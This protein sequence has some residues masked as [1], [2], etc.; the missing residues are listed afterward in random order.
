MPILSVPIYYS[1]CNYSPQTPVVADAHHLVLVSLFID[2]SENQ[3]DK[4]S[5]WRDRGDRKPIIKHEYFYL[6]IVVCFVL[7]IVVLSRNS[8][9]KD[10]LWSVART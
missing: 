4:R 2:S 3:S 8:H 9:K 10:C 6:Q 1:I 7:Q 5:C